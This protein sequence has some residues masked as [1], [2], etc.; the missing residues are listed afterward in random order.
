MNRIECEQL[1]DYLGGWLSQPQ[2]ERFAAHLADCPECRRECQQQ[3][4]IDV[5]LAQGAR[6]PESVPGEL[7]ERIEREVGRFS[8]RRQLQWAGGL[9][10][11]A[12]LV[13]AVGIGVAT[14]PPGTPSEPRPMVRRP[15]QPVVQEAPSGPVPEEATKSPPEVHVALGDPSSAILVRKQTAA[16]NVS[17]VWIYPTAKRAPAEPLPDDD[18][19]PLY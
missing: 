18:S 7:V 9:A 8:R 5:L 2:R 13:L 10:A 17:I 3:Q 19:F 4:R 15:S 12:L 14:R 11:A 16:P 1:D 6:C